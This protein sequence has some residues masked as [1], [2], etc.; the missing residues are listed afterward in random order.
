MKP[1]CK[2][3]QTLDRRVCRVAPRGAASRS[4]IACTLCSATLKIAGI[5]SPNARPSPLFS[6]GRCRTSLRHRNTSGLGGAGGAGSS[7]TGEIP[8]PSVSA[9]TT[10]DP[11]RS[12]RRRRRVGRRY[13][14]E[15]KAGSGPTGLGLRG[16]EEG[17]GGAARRGSCVARLSRGAMRAFSFF[18]RC[19][20]VASTCQVLGF[21]PLPVAVYAEPH[22]REVCSPVN[23]RR[24]QQCFRS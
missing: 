11:S 8:P 10:L 18:C 19:G 17:A 14:E 16:G 4:G 24:S 9:A 22:R 2:R 6:A 3:H 23:Q 7:S 21:P 12:R 1:D 20:C 5:S 13:A 15:R